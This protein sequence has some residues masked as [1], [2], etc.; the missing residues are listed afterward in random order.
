M[1]KCQLPQVPRLRVELGF[2]FKLYYKLLMLHRFI[3]YLNRGLEG[4]FCKFAD[5]TTLGRAVD[6]LKGGK[7]VQRDVDK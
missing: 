7:A 5:S 4:V 1:C 6:S 3:N 2:F